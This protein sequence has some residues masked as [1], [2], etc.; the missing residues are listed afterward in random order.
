MVYTTVDA[1]GVISKTT[2]TADSADFDGATNLAHLVGNVKITN[3]NPALFAEPAVMVGDKAT[4][5][6][7][8]NPG[9]DDFRFRVE[10]SPGVSSITVTPKAK[11][12]Q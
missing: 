5:N 9:P 4:V 1:N 12:T 3:D 7:A 2:A 6:L 8:P 10:S 11:E